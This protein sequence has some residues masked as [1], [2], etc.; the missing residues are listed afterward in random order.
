M[1]EGRRATSTREPLPKRRYFFAGFLIAAMLFSGVAAVG[2]GLWL[3]SQ[4]PEGGMAPLGTIALVVAPATTIIA[5]LS[6]ILVGL[7]RDD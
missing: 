5:T 7:L 6:T 2:A 3:V 4:T 1:R